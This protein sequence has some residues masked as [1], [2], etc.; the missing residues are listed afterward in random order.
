MKPGSCAKRTSDA[1][2]RLGPAE[3]WAT[4]GWPGSG[5]AAVARVAV[6][7]LVLASRAA[8]AQ[9]I[10]AHAGE[11]GADT[12]FGVTLD[13]RSSL[14]QA[15]AI[16][17]DKIIATGT[18]ADIAKHADAKTHVIDLGGRTVIPGLIDFAD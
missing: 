13:A 9:V 15:L 18:S 16:R 1:G 4:T 5:S 14:V 17:E 10:A 12:G 8:R 6:A 3:R 7:A 2:R 11:V